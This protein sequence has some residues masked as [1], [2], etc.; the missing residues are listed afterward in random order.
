MP[1][2]QYSPGGAPAMSLTGALTI[3]IEAEAVSASS[4]LLASIATRT[5]PNASCGWS[6]RVRGIR[7]C[8][9]GHP[10]GADRRP[11]QFHSA[12][13]AATRARS[14]DRTG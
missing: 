10:P 3:G 14:I 11:E 9:R 6:E 5:G 4:R 8:E 13:P 12:S 2:S 1:P 7:L